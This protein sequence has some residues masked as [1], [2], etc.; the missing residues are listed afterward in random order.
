MSS[1]VNDSFNLYLHESEEELSRVI[2]LSPMVAEFINQSKRVMILK[3]STMYK[4]FGT[5]S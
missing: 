2:N 1:I 5:E 3:V 4:E